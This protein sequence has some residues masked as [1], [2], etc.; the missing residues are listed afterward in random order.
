MQ[1]QFLIGTL[2]TS[3]CIFRARSRTQVS[4]PHRYA[5]NGGIDT[6]SIRQTVMFQFLIGTLKTESWGQAYEIAKEVSIPHRY[7]KNACFSPWGVLWHQVS[8][9][10]RYA[11]NKHISDYL[12]AD[13]G[14]SIPH[15]YAKNAGD[16]SF[17]AACCICFN[18]S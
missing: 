7:A 13:F 11:K 10:H 15:R 17:R 3:F 5:K 18:S 1:F 14:V 6:I 9:P 4:I 8:I 2:K 16:P 12:T